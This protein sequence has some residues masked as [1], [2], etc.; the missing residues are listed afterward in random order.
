MDFQA[1]FDGLSDAARRTRSDYHVTLGQMIERLKACQ[2]DKV[3]VCSDAISEHPG[4]ASSYRGYYSDLAFE[5]TAEP[6]TVGALL[7]E[8]EAALGRPF[9]GYK[10]G[11]FP[12][13]ADTPLW[14]APYGHS[15]GRAIVDVQETDGAVTLVIKQV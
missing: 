12:M 5:P 6:I 13:E 4:S 15:G 8:C 7:A 3:V 9:T 2:P 10:G 14:V 1:L 11:E